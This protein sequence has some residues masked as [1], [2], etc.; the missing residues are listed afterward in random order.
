V[1]ISILTLSTTALI[2]VVLSVANKPIVLSV[3]MLSVIILSDVML[4]AM[5]PRKTHKKGKNEA[6]NNCN[7]K[8]SLDSNKTQIFSKNRSKPFFDLEVGEMKS[9]R[10]S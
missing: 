10:Q 8:N 4:S 9:P 3:V 7:F 2:T 6:F 5:A 1:T